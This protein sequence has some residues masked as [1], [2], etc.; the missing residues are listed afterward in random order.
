MLYRV[1]LP[2]INSSIFNQAF[3]G[4]KEEEEEELCWE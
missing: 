2:V 4:I 3:I 1:S